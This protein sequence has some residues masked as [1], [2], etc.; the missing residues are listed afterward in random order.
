MRNRPDK[1]WITDRVNLS[2]VCSTCNFP[3]MDGDDVM[4][5]IE[6]RTINCFKC[7]EEWNTKWPEEWF[8]FHNK[9]EKWLNLVFHKNWETMDK[10][11]KYLDS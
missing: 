9:Y 11:E 3:L 8:W 10:Y 2:N 5:E 7:C 1:H 6:S 4:I